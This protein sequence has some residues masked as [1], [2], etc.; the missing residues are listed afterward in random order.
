MTLHENWGLLD[1]DLCGTSPG[2]V[3]NT[4]GEDE[5]YKTISGM[6]PFGKFPWIARFAFAENV[7]NVMKV[8]YR[9]QGVLINR[10]NVMTSAS[11][12]TAPEGG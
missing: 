8:E 3:P 4:P 5:V 10:R 7:D 9:C 12:I 1:H 11:C 6:A 2:L